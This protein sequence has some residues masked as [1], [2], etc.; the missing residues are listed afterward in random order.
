MNEMYLRVLS[1][2]W[3]PFLNT[4]VCQWL[5]TGRWFSPGPP[6][7]S[8]NKP[9][10]HDITEI[11]LKVALNTIKPNHTPQYTWLCFQQEDTVHLVIN[12]KKSQYTSTLYSKRELTHKIVY[13]LKRIWG[14]YTI[15]WVTDRSINWH[16]ARSAMNYLLYPCKSVRRH[17][18]VIVYLA[19]GCFIP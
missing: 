13:G 4:L 8:T 7:F 12:G 10:Y 18:F 19:T 16:L 6:V 15:L 3:V 17:V 11:L 1:V 9:D 2:L 14:P 5:A